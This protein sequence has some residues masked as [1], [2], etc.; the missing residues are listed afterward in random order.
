MTPLP[1]LP[2]KAAQALARIGVDTLEGVVACRADGLP[3][4]DGMDA[5]A[6]AILDRA[7]DRHGW[8]FAESSRPDPEVE[9]PHPD[10]GDRPGG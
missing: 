1:A 4:L 2:D 7:L 8:S 9:A 5:E 6:L 10:H 3:L